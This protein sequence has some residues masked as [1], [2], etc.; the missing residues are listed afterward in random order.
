M[1]LISAASFFMPSTSVA[2]VSD[3]VDCSAAYQEFAV[4]VSCKVVTCDSKFSTFV[5]TWE[6]PF[7]AY[8]RDLKTFRP[9]RNQVKY[10]ADECLQNIDPSH[11]G[12]GD[13]LIIGRRIDI[14][15]AFKNLPGKTEFG[16]LITGRHKD[17]L[18]FLKMIN[19]KGETD[20][21]N[22]TLVEYTL[23]SQDEKTVTSVWSKSFKEA[24]KGQCPDGKTEDCAYDL[25]FTVS[26]GKRMSDL[27]NDTRDVSVKMEM[28]LSTSGEKVNDSVTNC[29]YHSKAN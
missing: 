24:Y 18:P 13:S 1:G 16:L 3:V 19:P 20:Q 26:D 8:N 7:E 6:G 17:G 29:G 2:K 27:K 22:E 28:F 25:K 14:Y 12:F 15:P 4:R 11:A 9:Y 5:G 10:S 21:E 23:E